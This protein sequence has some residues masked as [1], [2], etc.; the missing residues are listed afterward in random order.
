MRISFEQELNKSSEKE[1][2]RIKE[3]SEAKLK[4]QEGDFKEVIKRLKESEERNNE[5]VKALDA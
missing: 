5:R 3:E 2:A 1:K 4:A